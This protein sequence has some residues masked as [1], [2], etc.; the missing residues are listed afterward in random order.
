[1]TS[2]NWFKVQIIVHYCET[3]YVCYRAHDHGISRVGFSKL[4]P[5]S[6]LGG[7]APRK[8]IASWF[9]LFEF[10]NICFVACEKLNSHVCSHDFTPAL[11]PGGDEP[12]NVV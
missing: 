7:V 2:V 3:L 6:P 12:Q 5:V 9:D 8:I 1:M 11:P 4:I 10:Q